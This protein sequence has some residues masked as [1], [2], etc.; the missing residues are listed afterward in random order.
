MKFFVALFLM[1]GLLAH[2][3]EVRF[4][5]ALPELDGRITLGVFDSSGKLVRRLHTLADLKEFAIDDNGLVAKWDG[6]NDA[7]QN[8][9]AGAYFVKGFV[10][11]DEVEAQGE[12]Y[13]FND[14]IENEASPRLSWLEDFGR[15]D[16]GS[17][18]GLGIGTAAVHHAFRYVEKDG[19][20]W[21]REFQGKE[22]TTVG[23]LSSNELSVAICLDTQ[24]DFVTTADG[25]VR[26]GGGH[27]AG[28]PVA[29]A[30]AKDHLFLA[31]PDGIKRYQI[32]TW[33]EEPQIAPPVVLQ[34]L[35]VSGS[36]LLGGSSAKSGVLIYDFDKWTETPIPAMARSVSFG[37]ENTIWIVGQESAE[38]EPFA[39]QFDVQ[40]EFL[41]SYRGDLPAH[42]ISSSRTSE[43]VALLE[44]DAQTQ[45][46]LVLHLNDGSWEIV[47]EK[48]IVRSSQ[49]GFVDGKLLSNAGDAV[50]LKQQ[51]VQISAGGLSEKAEKIVLQ[52]VADETGCWLETANGLRLFCVSERGGYS[53]VV[54][55][56]GDKSDGMKVY[57]GDGAVV[58][59]FQIKG[60]ENIVA[61]EVGEIDLP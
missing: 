46:F 20:L 37:K 7:G 55:A 50:Q 16:D 45:R 1:A 15:L 51:S 40:G 38:K 9:P 22:K 3:S 35:S 10:T 6:K 39:G 41:R 43:E 33:Q 54:L 56:P 42:K 59:E 28:A 26:S 17:I 53:R 2:A 11:G 58:S 48:T 12:A 31:L 52:V 29:V 5:F 44:Q 18:V 32:S 8:L 61:L 47:L 4:T 19:F 13:H 24:I 21:K 49:F 34:S 57:V 27:V 25:E 23:L 36:S 60:L 14:W 30:L